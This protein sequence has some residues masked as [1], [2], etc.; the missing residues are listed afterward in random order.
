M[1]EEI[2][3]SM[4]KRYVAE[5]SEFEAKL[6]SLETEANKTRDTEEDIAHWMEAIRKSVGVKMLDRKILGLLVDRVV[7]HEKMTVDG[8]KRQKVEI[9]YRFVG[10]ISDG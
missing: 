10:R 9:F 7:V 4:S 1:P 8:V 5:K 2:F 3:Q 6:E